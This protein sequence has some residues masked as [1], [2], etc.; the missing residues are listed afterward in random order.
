MSEVVE[1]TVQLIGSVYVTLRLL[2]WD[3]SRLPDAMRARAW[4]ESTML[5]AS[6][7]FAPLCLLL[8]YTRTRR[9]F[10]GFALGLLALVT[11][12]VFVSL[13][14]AACAWLLA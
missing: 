6:L 5:S 12:S 11:T 13:V 1:L 2:R 4:P 14:S 9:S 8:H 10:K 3:T 7:A